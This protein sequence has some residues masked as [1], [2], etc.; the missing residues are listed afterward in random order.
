MPHPAAIVGMAVTCCHG[1]TPPM[2]S[3]H[4]LNFPI[5]SEWALGVSQ[6]ERVSPLSTDKTDTGLDVRAGARGLLV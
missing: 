2:A 1:Y 6:Q 3:R 5:F 4:C